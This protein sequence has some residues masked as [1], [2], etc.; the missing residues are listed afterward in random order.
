M[1]ARK[2]EFRVT[3]YRTVQSINIYTVIIHYTDNRYMD[4]GL[5]H[6]ILKSIIKTLHKFI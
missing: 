6:S 5:S 2:G 3:E 4:R 1:A